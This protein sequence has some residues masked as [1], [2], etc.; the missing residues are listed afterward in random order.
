MKGSRIRG[1]EGRERGRGGQC[2]EGDRLRNN[3]VKRDHEKVGCREEG[4]GQNR[5][6]KIVPRF[7]LLFDVMS[8]TLT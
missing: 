1:K 2:E 7:Y 8:L 5:L 4:G 6:K 3:G